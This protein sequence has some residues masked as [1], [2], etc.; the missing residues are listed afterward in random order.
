MKI[1]NILTQLFY[2]RFLCSVLGLLVLLTCS[3]QKRKVFPDSVY[4]SQT[5]LAL[6]LTYPLPKIRFNR[7]IKLTP[8]YVHPNLKEDTLTKNIRGDIDWQFRSKKA[9]IAWDLFRDTIRNPGKKNF[10]LIEEKSTR[11][12]PDIRSIHLQGS[13]SAPAGVRYIFS[14]SSTPFIST[15]YASFYLSIKTGCFRPIFRDTVSLNGKIINYNN[16]GVYELTLERRLASFAF[17]MGYVLQFDK[18]CFVNIGGGFGLEQLFWRFEEYNL[19]YQ[20]TGKSWAIHES[21]IKQIG[22]PCVETGVMVLCKNLLF[23]A[24]ISATRFKV[25]QLNAGIGMQLNHP[26]FSKKNRYEN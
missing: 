16:S 12:L 11:E 1:N 17:L 2:L 19:D 6:I 15:E 18:N 10:Y 26:I 24:G 23:S 14:K 8:V 3:A 4:F 9:L 20:R 7:Q 5:K 22:F 21:T 13:N 25:Y